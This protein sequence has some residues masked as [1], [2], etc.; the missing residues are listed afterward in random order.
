MELLLT[1]DR[2]R[3]IVTP[4]TVRFVTCAVFGRQW[5]GAEPRLR[6][7]VFFCQ[8]LSYKNGAGTPARGQ[9]GSLRS[10]RAAPPA[11]GELRF[12]QFAAMFAGPGRSGWSHGGAGQRPQGH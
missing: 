5:V 3:V 10:A 7:R 6:I 2:A 11:A 12:E 9:L 1:A 4:N 8:C